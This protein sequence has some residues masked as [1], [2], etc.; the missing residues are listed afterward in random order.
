MVVERSKQRF[1]RRQQLRGNRTRRGNMHRR[2]EDVI[3]GLPK[4]DVV[5]GVNQPLLS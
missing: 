4:V 1:V 2:G 3:R 5:I